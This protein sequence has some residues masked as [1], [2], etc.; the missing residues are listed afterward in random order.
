MN[1]NLDPSKRYDLT[2]RYPED[3]TASVQTVNQVEL[4]ATLRVHSV[5]LLTCFQDRG[6][7]QMAGGPKLEWKPVAVEAKS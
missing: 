2:V 7:V 1:F 5:P 3:G 6:V 4:V